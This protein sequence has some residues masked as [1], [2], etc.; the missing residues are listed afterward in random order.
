MNFGISTANSPGISPEFF[1]DAVSSFRAIEVAG[2]PEAGIF[3]ASKWSFPRVYAVEIMPSSFTRIIAEQSRSIIT[4]FRRRLLDVFP[5]LNAFGVSSVMMDFSVEKAFIDKDYALCLLDLLRTVF[6]LFQ[7]HKTEFLV[8]VRI[9]FMAAAPEEYLNF[10]KAC[11]FPML[12]FALN[13]YPH[14]LKP[15]FSPAEYLRWLKFDTA[16]VRFIYEPE[17]GNRL[18][19]GHITPWF[20]YFRDNCIDTV[21]IFAPRTTEIATFGDAF[22]N[23][24]ES[25]AGLDKAL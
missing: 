6:P 12:K 7:K 4:D 11:M 20:E 25:I 22:E 23:I 19:K 9:P 21:F 24:K 18:V 13:I 16:C 17:A 2:D 1:S 10:K 15:G 5:R 14:E 3:P 8:P